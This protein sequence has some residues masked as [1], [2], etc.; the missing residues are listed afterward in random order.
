[1]LDVNDMI[2]FI[3]REG[4]HRIRSVSDLVFRHLFRYFA[5]MLFNTIIYVRI[6]AVP[7]P[8]VSRELLKN[9]EICTFQNIPESVAMSWTI[10]VVS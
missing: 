4:L 9:S 7:R 3:W 1:M 2:I 5:Y 6:N 8:Q 10:N